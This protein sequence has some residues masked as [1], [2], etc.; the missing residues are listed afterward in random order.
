MPER[1]WPAPAK[2]NRFLHITGRRADGMHELQTVFQ[3][4]DLC[5]ELSFTVRT[6]A[7]IRHLNPLA[8][9]DPET[10]LTVRAA[11]LLQSETGCRLGAEIHINKRLPLGGGL[12]G[13]SSDCA[14][15][16]V[17][18]NR[19]WGLELPVERL[20][21]LGLGLGAD[22]PVFVHGRA[23][24]AEGV[25]ERLTPV[26]LD[27]PWFVVIRP[28]CEV[29]TAAV[30]AAPG[31]TRSTPPMTIR[32]FL[33]GGGGNDCEAV[34]R[35]L[36]PAVA[37]AQDWLGRHAPA[38]L[39]GTGACIFAPFADRETAATIAARIP[40]RWQGFIA[41]GLNESPLLGRLQQEMQ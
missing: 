27:E 37:E 26:E 28:D 39:T 34:V 22:V 8:G 30:F 9:V 5:D 4:I 13:G 36:F 17:A 16:L 19:L 24:W 35:E 14:T 32:G 7:G 31:L 23:A 33:D 25:G 12:G 40:A 1:P 10:D 11:R 20:A 29:S 15:T 21:D 3:F 41:R 38:R 18:L 6:D 2:L